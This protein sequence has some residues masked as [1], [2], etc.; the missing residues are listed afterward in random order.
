[1]TYP[2]SI[3]AKIKPKMTKE[4]ALAKAQAEKPKFREEAQSVK[5]GKIASVIQTLTEIMNEHP[6]AKLVQGYYGGTVEIRYKVQIPVE[7]RVR[8]ILRSDKIRYDNARYLAQEKHDEEAYKAR[9]VDASVN[10][11]RH[12]SCC[13]CSR[14]L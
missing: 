2:K 7:E 14:G 1:M 3:Y 13:A 10:A 4:E 5:S 12:C 6:D 8:E 11:A 9:R